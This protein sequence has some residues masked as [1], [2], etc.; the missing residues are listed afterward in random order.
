M[1][2]TAIFLLLSMGAQAS[3]SVLDCV[4]TA[5]YVDGFTQDNAVRLCRGVKDIR[6]LRACAGKAKYI[7]NQTQEQAADIC[8]QDP[9]R[10][11]IDR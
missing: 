3:D 4:S 5:K 6:S 1:I 11:T 10:V 9:N 8:T 7:Q 2:T